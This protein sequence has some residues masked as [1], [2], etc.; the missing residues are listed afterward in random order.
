[1]APAT[2]S[3]SLPGFVVDEATQVDGMIQIKAHRVEPEAVCPA[4][5]HGSCRVRSYYTRTL[6]DFPL[7]GQ[8]VCLQLRNRRFRR[9]KGKCAS[10]TF[11]QPLPELAVKH[12]Q[13]TERFTCAAHA[14]GLAL[15][16]Q[17]SQRLAARLALQVSADT[18]LRIIR[19]AAYRSLAVAGHRGG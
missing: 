7:D 1:M 14:I 4:C 5:Q 15:G 2:W 6:K 9:T 17:A 3:F 11:A 16:G 8:A 10:A 13:R 19:A 12:A 18:I